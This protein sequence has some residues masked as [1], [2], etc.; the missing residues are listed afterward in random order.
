MMT[1]HEMRVRQRLARQVVLLADELVVVQ[2]VELLSGTHLLPTHQAGEAIQVENLVPC[3]PDEILRAYPLPATTA[4]RPVSP[5]EVIPAEELGLPRETLVLQR[6][7]AVEAADALDVP[8]SVQ[9]VQQV[10]IHNWF[11]ASCT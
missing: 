8:C 6:G 1:V 4:F 11:L 3:L 7:S 2:D 10:L 5:E 9:N